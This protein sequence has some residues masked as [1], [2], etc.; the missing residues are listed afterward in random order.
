M[1]EGEEHLKGIVI[2][3]T[4][5]SLTLKLQDS[6]SAEVLTDQKTGFERGDAPATLK[7][8]VVG[9]RVV[10]YASMKGKKF[11][12]RIVKLSTAPSSPDGGPSMPHSAGG[13]KMPEAPVEPEKAAAQEFTC[14]MHPEVRSANPGKCPKCGM[15]LQ[16]VMPAKGTK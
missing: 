16:P 12:A 6:E 3:A 8:V 14:P 15:K 11:L 5:T 2:R 7:D 9:E 1:A 4:G 10:V 13:M